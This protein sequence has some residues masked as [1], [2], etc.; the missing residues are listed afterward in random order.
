MNDKLEKIKEQAI[1]LFKKT[2]VEADKIEVKEFLTKSV[3][4]SKKIA[5]E[6]KGQ[7]S[8]LLTKKEDGSLSIISKI[9]DFFDGLNV[10]LMGSYEE[11]EAYE[12]A[13]ESKKSA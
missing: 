12:K 3:E 1:E 9:N 4:K 5:T 2:K 8:K 7:S 10:K 13:K 6:I 11:I